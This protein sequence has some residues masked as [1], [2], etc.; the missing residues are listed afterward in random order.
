MMNRVVRTAS[1]IL[2]AVLLLV[3]WSPWSAQRISNATKTP[4]VELTQAASSANSAT[5]NAT[6]GPATFKAIETLRV[7]DRVLTG[8]PTD[9]DRRTAVNPTS[10]RKLKLSATT[11][12]KDGTQ[13]RFNVETLQPPEYLAEHSCQVGSTL[14]MPL[15]VQEMGCPDGL[16]A[17]VE[18]IEP[19][20]AIQDSDGRVILTTVNHL[21]TA[22]RALTVRDQSGNTETIQTTDYHPF[23][24]ETHQD[25]VQAGKLAVGENVR[26]LNLHNALV[27][28]DS[29]RIAGAHLVFNMTVESEHVYRVGNH[30]I[31]VH[32]NCPVDAVFGLAGHND[33]LAKHLE[34]AETYPFYNL[35]KNLE[36]TN[37]WQAIES[38]MKQSNK[39]HFTFGGFSVAEYE[40]FIANYKPG[41]Y[42]Q[43]GNDWTNLELNLLLSYFPE[44][45]IFYSGPSSNIIPFNLPFKKKGH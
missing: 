5:E 30:A 12:W 8:L 38:A 23:W 42:P 13:D 10:W 44:K 43:G 28:I 19:C 25:W 2:V 31:L 35:T 40:K 14:P 45:T 16:M 34:M 27:V 32:N 9:T 39:N 29:Q 6:G 18:S 21:N 36:V 37:S 15:D 26:G 1:W 41:N 24:S 3:G 7:G 4:G 33:D 11:L 20:P 17:V 22:C